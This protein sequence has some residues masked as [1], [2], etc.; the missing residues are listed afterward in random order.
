MYRSI[1]V[2]LVILALTGRL[3]AQD[4][5]TESKPALRHTM[6]PEEY[7]RRHEIGRN[8]IETPPPIGPVRNVAEYD[9]MQGALIRYPFGIPISLIK[10]MATD[11]MVTTIVASQTQKTTVLNQYVANGV[12]T[13][14]CNFLIAPTDSYWTRDYGPWFATDSSNQIGIVDFPYNRPRP[15][16]DEIPKLFAAMLGIP[17]YGMN[18]ITAGGNYMTDGL[19]ISSSTDLVY[20]ENPTQTSQQVNDKMFDYLGIEN[21]RVVPD[22]NIS[23][24]IDHIDCWG[25]FLGPDK[26]LIRQVLP[27]DP[28]YNALENQ[29]TYWASQIC[30][31]GYNY[32]VFRVKT[33][34]DQPYTNSVILNNKVLVPFMN[35]AWDDSA[36]AA[37]EAA[38]PGYTVN[39]FI[40]SGSSGWLSTDA[41]HCRVMGVADV[42][43]LYIR[44]IPLSGVKPCES[45]YQVS[46]TILASSQMPVIEDS[47]RIHYRVNGGPYQVVLMTSQSSSDYS[48]F[49]PKQSA[50]SLVEYYL[51]AADESG[52][53]ETMPLIGA[54]DPFKFTTNY[55][56]LTPV[57]DTLWFLTPD[58]C[59]NGKITQ[60]HNYLTN[61]ITL[62]TI[63]Q[64]GNS[65]PWMVDSVS[66]PGYPSLIDPGDSVAVRVRVPIVVAL[67]PGMTF[68]KDSLEYTTSAGSNY[69]IIMIN[70][71]L[72]SKIN[73]AQ[74]HNEIGDPYPNPFKD[75]IT[76]P[77]SLDKREQ[78][79][80]EIVDINGRLITTLW[81]GM[82]EAGKR[83]I[84]WDGTD[85]AGNQVCSG[86]YL[87]K[88]TTRAKSDIQ[89]LLLIR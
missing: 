4:T 17:W 64:Y 62:D 55:T 80:I 14:H 43:L 42:G 28:E 25:K 21:F 36:K 51:S 7:A 12:D 5:L 65:L 66:V 18:V 73:E 15:N 34:Q 56:N 45:D 77:L 38:M 82:A 32:R 29:A 49:I 88:F 79:R 86:I 44:H 26:I 6:T 53:S 72:L 37:Y 54:A 68:Y 78:I 63:Q 61:R 9:R 75:H 47:V 69:V 87:L 33:P 57:P 81:D 13:S 23:S 3:W 70:D 16:D 52:R 39:G 31:Y 24:T 41:L 59:L 11:V 2:T 76:I 84:S 1:Y 20:V 48:G 50:G 60:L 30:S 46:A 35:S 10:E 71:D 8:F 58:D 74:T 27:T 40:A 67:L 83:F 85:N 89:K 22:P 19:G